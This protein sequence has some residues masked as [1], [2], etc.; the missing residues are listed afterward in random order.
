MYQINAE[1]GRFEHMVRQGAMNAYVLPKMAYNTGTAI[2]TPDP[3][4]YLLSAQLWS[5][6]ESSPMQPQPGGAGDSLILREATSG[7]LVLVHR[8]TTQA[9]EPARAQEAEEAVTPAMIVEFVRRVFALNMSDAAEAFRVSRPTIYQW[10][11][12]MDIEQVRSHSDRERLKAL[13]RITKLWAGRE[14]LVGRWQSMILPSGKSVLDL[15]KEPQLNVLALTE[16]HRVL[17]DRKDILR[18]EDHRRA[19]GAA[20]ALGNAF[21]K[22]GEAQGRRGKP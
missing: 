10:A 4:S 18:R 11:K 6:L 19:Q 15:L 12:L 22:L 9:A 13:H 2:S 20:A 8:L 21:A 7:G 1:S 14:P 16:A 3:A 5:L 17:A